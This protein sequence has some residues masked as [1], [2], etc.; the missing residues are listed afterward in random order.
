MTPRSTMFTPRVREPLA[1]VV[2]TPEPSTSSSSD[3]QSSSSGSPSTN[4]SPADPSPASPILPGELG[5]DAS[6]NSAEK[7]RGIP[8]AGMSPFLARLEAVSDGP[9]GA[10]AEPLEDLTRGATGVI[11]NGQKSL[12]QEQRG[13]DSSDFGEDDAVS[14]SSG[15]AEDG[16]EG[17]GGREL[18]SPEGSV[19]LRGSAGGKDEAAESGESGEGGEGAKKGKSPVSSAAIKRYLIHRWVALWNLL[20]CQASI[21]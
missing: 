1:D 4:A 6:T 10:P 20:F 5:H 17:S 18:S 21:L 8:D 12:G 11:G 16:S 15:G 13:A 2:E 14:V 9:S 3:P 7:R 19:T